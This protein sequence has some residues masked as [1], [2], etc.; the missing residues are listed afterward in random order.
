M[1]LFSNNFLMVVYYWVMSHMIM[2]ILVLW[3]VRKFKNLTEPVDYNLNQ[4]GDYKLS[5]KSLH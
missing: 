3:T 2:N 1:F 5:Y 4:N